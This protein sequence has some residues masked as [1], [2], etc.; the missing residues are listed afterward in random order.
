MTRAVLSLGA[1]LGDRAATIRE[2]LRLLAEDIDVAV[3][4]VSRFIENPAVG[5]PADSPSFLNAAAEISTTLSPRELLQ[6]LL[7]TERRLG[8]ERRQRWAPRT[9]DL[10]LLL[11]ED[12]MIDEPD[13]IIPHPLMHERRFVLEPLAEIAPNAIHPVLH[14]PVTKL[15]ERL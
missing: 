10:D 7:T 4:R 13:L 2:A 5:G 1:N 14:T 11:Y 8:R 9:I 6:R 3:T 15:L 12:C